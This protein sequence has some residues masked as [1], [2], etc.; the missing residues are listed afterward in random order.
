MRSFL[1]GLA[2]LGI[3]AGAAPAFAQDGSEEIVV[4]GMRRLNPDDDDDSAREKVVPLPAAVQMLRRTADFAVQQVIV[5]SDT[6]DEDDANA[7]VYAMTRKAI[8]LAAG[9][10]VQLATGEIVVEP[11]TAANYKE[12]AI[13]E[14]DEENGQAVKFLVKVPLAP[15]IDA[16]T[17]LA[18]I[19]KFIKA[20]PAVGRAEIKAYSEL[21]L[22]VVNPEQYRG[23]IIDLIAKDTGETSAR[24]GTGYGV[25][26]TGLDRPV[27][28]KRASLT[29]VQLFLPAAS[30]VRPRD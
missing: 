3:L 27:Q 21:T 11:L 12:L 30:T 2:A 15:G 24:F 18:R 26:V 23:A 8:E 19:D 22:S 1:T 17:A 9:A 29:E 6:I 7:E 5:V 10:G 20:V 16:K 25:E 28:W 14:D 4:T 13:G